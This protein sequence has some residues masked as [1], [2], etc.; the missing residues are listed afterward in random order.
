M[1][2]SE[3]LSTFL[4]IQMHTRTLTQRPHAWIVPSCYVRLK[5]NLEQRKRTH[6]SS[7]Q[8]SACDTQ[9]DCSRQNRQCCLCLSRIDSWIRAL[10][11]SWYFRHFHL[12]R[13]WSVITLSIL[14][15]VY[16]DWIV[17]ALA[18]EVRA[19]G[20]TCALGATRKWFKR[21]PVA[22][23]KEYTF[24]PRNVDVQQIICH[25]WLR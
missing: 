8:I 16:W 24:C 6:M 21:L 2:T 3:D 19:A 1:Y 17:L 13:S 18:N 4:Q 20:A 23:L 5:E 25:I 7:L 12:A 14:A 11:C 9:G 10:G 22:W 15:W